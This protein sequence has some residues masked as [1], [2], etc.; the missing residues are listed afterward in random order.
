M[1]S[2]LN[3]EGKHLLWGRGKEESHSG[4]VIDHYR[5]TTRASMDGPGALIVVVNEKCENY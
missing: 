2:C 3:D 4:A 5:V 1:V